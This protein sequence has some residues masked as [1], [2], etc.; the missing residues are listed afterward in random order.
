MDLFQNYILWFCNYLK[1]DSDEHQIFSLELEEFLPH[2]VDQ[3]QV[4]RDVWSKIFHQCDHTL[5]FP[6]AADK[7]VVSK[8]HIFREMLIVTSEGLERVLALFDGRDGDCA[9]QIHFAI[10]DILKNAPD[11]SEAKSR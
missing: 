2:Q 7:G 4:I 5:S 11:R 1:F 9:K 6:V 3:E 10:A 8:E